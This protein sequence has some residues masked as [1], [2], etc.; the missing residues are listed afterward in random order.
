MSK[1]PSK[2]P[3]KPSGPVLPQGLDHIP[4]LN[5]LSIA[6]RQR[7]LQELTETRY[8]KH[9]YIFR[10]GDPTEYFHIVKEGT[11]KCVKSTPEGKECTLKM[12][13]PGDLFCCDA[14]AFDGTAHPG[15]A[16]PMGD[17]SILRMKKKSYF[18][19]LRR[20]PDAAMEV[21]KY[22]GNRLNEAQEK[23]K[24]LALDRADQRLASLLVDLAARNGIADQNGIRL[25]VRM[26]RQDMANMVGI[27]TETAIRIMSR[28]KR[29]RLVSGTANRLLIRDLKGLKALASA[30]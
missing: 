5:I 25:T 2:S 11:V 1:R 24:D 23:T 17:V 7:V 8:G 4:L 21:I 27:T 10:E 22:L 30:S 18:E 12:L 13:M 14:A 9:D 19:M 20:N 6:D 26:T 3:S 15:S 29:D 28:F 16:Q